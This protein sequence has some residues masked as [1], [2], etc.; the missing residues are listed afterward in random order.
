MARLTSFSKLLITIGMLVGAVF[1]V[2]FLFSDSKEVVEYKERHDYENVMN[3]VGVELSE[4]ILQLGKKSLVIAEV[5][6][7]EGQS[8]NLGRYF[9]EE[10]STELVNSSSNLTLLDRSQLSN[11]IK[12]QELDAAGLLDQTTLVNL[13][14]LIGTEVIITGKY[15]VIDEKVKIWFRAID[16]EKGKAIFAQDY[17]VL[18]NAEIES[19]YSSDNSWFD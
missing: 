7:L 12:E 10:L 2:K 18:I 6:N 17:S 14:E 15:K 11:L 3:S 19:I 5:S 13:G 1:F 4:R 8:K 16:I 9:T